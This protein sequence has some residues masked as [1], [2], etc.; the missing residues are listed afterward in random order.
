[1]VTL[2]GI[3]WPEVEV[4]VMPPIVTPVAV[5][6]CAKGVLAVCWR[7]SEMLMVKL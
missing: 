3:C 6:V 5:I 7:L 1:M 4:V 2:T